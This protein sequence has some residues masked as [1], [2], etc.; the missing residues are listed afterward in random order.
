MC[1]PKLGG[2][3]RT[4]RALIAAA[5]GA[6]GSIPSLG[7]AQ[8]TLTKSSNT[9]WTMTNG[10][11]TVVFDPQGEECTSIQLGVGG[12]AGPNL[13]DPGGGT[14]GSLNQE[15]AGT[16][17]GTGT[18]AFESNVGPNYV[19]VWTNVAS[20]G[21][22]V[23]PI[24][25]AFHYV[26]FANDPTVYC[27]EVLNHSATDPTTVVTNGVTM[28]L[29]VGQGQFLFRSNPSTFT[30]LY[31]I[32]TGPNQLGTTNA[33]TTT[34][35]P[36]TNSNFSTV[37][38]EHT[39]T[40]TS[41]VYYRTV[42]NV[43]YDLTGSGIAGDNGTNFF[44]KYDY[45][46][47]TQFFQAETMYGSQYAVSE[48]DP[49]PD[50]LTGGP[51]KQEL[52]WTDPGILN[53]EFL[54]DHYGI[55]SLNGYGTGAYPGYGYFPT[56]GI[57]TTKLYGPYGF[58]VSSISGTTAA[59]INANV[60]SAIPNDQAEF[61]T[62]TELATSGYMSNASR[63]SVQINASNSAG[64][65]SVE[66]NTGTNIVYQNNT[67]VLSEPGVNFQESTQGNQYTG[68]I[69]PNGTA[70]I[71]NVVPGTYRLSMY[72]LGQW[73]ETRVD[74]VQVQNGQVTIPQNL[75]FTPENFGTA[76]PIWTIGTPN[77]S[78]N[79]FMN[80]HTSSNT[81]LREY[82]GAY[83][84]WA[85]EQALG[86]PGYVSYNATATTIGGVAEPATN[87]ANDW[88][89]TQWS[90]F[91]PGLYDSTNNTT[92][93]Y[94]NTCPAYVTAGGGPAN[95]HGTAWQVH[96]AVTS[97][98]EAQGQY[99]VLSVGLVAQDASLVVTLNGHSETW[100]YNNF[101]PDDPAG[102]S[103]D[104]GFYQWAAFQFPTSDLSAVGADNEFTFGV[105]NH[106][107]GV[108]YD[109]LRME[110]T[111][112]SASPTV[113]GWDDYTYI[114]GSTQVAQ[115]DA[116]SIPTLTWT[117]SGGTGNG[118]TWDNGVNQNWTTGLVSW[119][120]SANETTFVSG[121]NT[122]FNDSNNG[123]YNVTLNTTVT[124]NS[125]LVNNSS[126]NYAISGTG[127]IAG[128]GTLT[129]SGADTL[130]LSTANTYTGGTNVTG[131]LLRV[132][133]NSAL[134]TGPVAV[135]SPAILDLDGYSPTIGNLS[136]SGTIDDVIAGGS[137]TLAINTST[138]SS[139][140][141]TIQNTT[142]AVAIS[143]SGTGTQILSGAN[144]YTG[145]TTVSGGTLQMGST[146]ALGTGP[147]AVAS[148]GILDLNGNS[149]TIGN[150]SGSGTVDNV[151]AGGSLTLAIDTTTSTNFSGV[152]QNTTGSVALSVSGTGTQALSGANTYTG[153]TDI[154]GGVLNVG[155]S[156]ALGST[157]IIGFGGGTL[158][159]SSNNTTDYSPRVSTAANQLY[160]VD[161]N[162]Q[163][164]T[165]ATA[166]TSSGGSLTKVG[167]GTLTLSGPN[168][169]SGGTAVTAG[170]LFI[171]PAGS[172][173]TFDGSGNLETANTLTAL[174]NGVLSIGGSGTVQ[175]A[176]GVTGQTFV[177]PSSYSA[178]PTSN[179]NI[180]SL[181][182]SG[183]G[184]LDI[185]NNRIIIDYSGPATDPIA[186]IEQW[187]K[188]GYYGIYGPSIISSDVATDDA[189][190]GLSYGIGYADGA[191]GLVA[192]LPSGEIEIMFTLLGDANLDGTV[193]SEDFSPFS[194]NLGQSGQ[195]W[196]DGDFNYDGTVNSEDFA[197]F[198]ANLG[199]SAA[200]AAGPADI[201][202][203][204]NGI[205][206]NSVS[207]PEP[208]VL[209]LLTL[210][211]G[212]LLKRRSRRPRR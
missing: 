43:T 166:L 142:G 135:T 122:V 12:G 88:I 86:T 73:G 111:N 182:I 165:W 64:W 82:D 8:V 21:T 211:G 49:S 212:G 197:P 118:M 173:A 170:T 69:A 53:M 174:P 129:K 19:D 157:G 56:P 158:Q 16:P 32:N 115:N 137:S 52:A 25:Y 153:G 29:S 91:D 152:I 95:Y 210:S 164:V 79:E 77:R 48:V 39:G 131:G 148:P 62:D 107:Y 30:N 55:D 81:D 171:A 110:I 94:N 20:T 185:G 184:T 105:S 70:T 61:A 128:S 114:N 120:N 15:F 63:G 161:T 136:G 189:A 57:A 167:T 172:N 87:N 203:A 9:D 187:I 163:N 6:L 7:H 145:G 18:Q 76:A 10:D 26:L 125:V 68:Q 85:E 178:Q 89:G 112:T 33:Q 97:A 93:N 96:F 45:S 151:T 133:N 160:S 104:A 84:F 200:M 123:N 195:M 116:V 193:N 176:D 144:T 27:Y 40:G 162:G 17:F 180:T 130:T 188:N 99:V 204:G 5:I 36:S 72:E 159:Y 66:A 44:T 139:F 132:G 126:G 140:S 35:I 14:N 208:S 155:S 38:N 205:T 121:A 58:T 108:M 113:T 2:R 22:S 23:N 74:G 109:A 138:S 143:V 191:D 169:F 206:L 83:N 194:H 124:P 54:S 103:G 80:G 183:T 149:P 28:G 150:L 98:Q 146:S 196:D 207:V 37:T 50:T 106:T 177:T 101:S 59:Q 147:V 198:S 201:V 42:S 24:T 90:T 51:T 3:N 127:R 192:G 186:S 209:A 60:I 102:R 75:K 141:G 179:I 11:L 92:D 175:L 67:V 156:G 168:T 100:S 46:T 117:N 202:A 47:Y 41:A 31:Q 190:S 71:S 4:E 1:T 199:Q 181:S 13:L 78:A 65:S 154:N 34:G 134:G 119:T